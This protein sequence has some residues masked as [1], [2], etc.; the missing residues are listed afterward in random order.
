MNNSSADRLTIR[1]MGQLA[2]SV[3]VIY[4]PLR[5]Y[6]LIPDIRQQLSWER[7]PLWTMEFIVIALFF[8]LWIAFIE[9]LQHQL[10]NWFGNDFLIEFKIP[11]Q[12]AT[13]IIACGMAIVFNIGFRALWT[14]TENALETQFG[15]FQKESAR[16]LS[17]RN[18]PRFPMK[19]GINSLTIMA[20]LSAFYLASYRR[21]YL[22]FEIARLKAEQMEKVNL[23]MQLTA[24]KNQVSPH[25]L[26]NNF[27]ILTSLVETNPKLSVQFINR[28]SKAYRYILEQSAHERISLKTELGFL[29][30]Y[31]FLL[32]TRFEQRLQVNINISEKEVG[33]YFIAPLTL[34]LLVENAVKHNR[35]S[36]EEPLTVMIDILGSYL[37]ISN[38]IQRRQKSEPSTRLGLQNIIERYRLM[39]DSPVLISENDGFF[40]VKIPLLQ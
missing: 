17:Y 10:Y 40:V 18:F 32:N 36:S 35:M 9:W 24:L 26:F 2:L 8:F 30:T 12:L 3:S 37:M 4:M 28:L 31:T 21:A 19:K 16:N 27:S 14:I 38:P 11:A 6:A 1:Q 15:I 25:F 5:M 22:K 7:I 29:E 34:Q 33:N 39:T 23:Q 20:L 13:F